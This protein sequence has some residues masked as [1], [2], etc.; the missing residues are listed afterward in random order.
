M[1][2]RRKGDLPIVCATWTEVFGEL[3]GGRV[4]GCVHG[5][6]C[7]GGIEG[8]PGEDCRCGVCA[9]QGIDWTGCVYLWMDV[10]ICHIF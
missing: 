1:Q 2:S 6:R 4:A 3:R 10:E 5:A 9:G 8:A 7:W